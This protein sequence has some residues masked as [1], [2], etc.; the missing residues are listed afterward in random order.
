METFGLKQCREI[1]DIKIAIKNAILDGVIA[2][3]YE[4]AYHYMLEKG[5]EMGLKVCTTS[6]KD[7]DKQEGDR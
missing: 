3:N 4:E 2:N 7:R 5:K 6:N 1:G